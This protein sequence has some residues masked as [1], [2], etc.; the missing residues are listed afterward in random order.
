MRR[1]SQTTSSVF[2]L[3]CVPHVTLPLPL[4]IG[5]VAEMRRN[6]PVKHESWTGSA[7]LFR[8]ARHDQHLPRPAPT[9]T[10]DEKDSDND[11][12][13]DEAFTAPPSCW[14]R[15]KL[16]QESCWKYCRSIDVNRQLFSNTKS[17]QSSMHNHQDVEFS[18][19][20]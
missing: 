15:Q 2:W 17:W 9:T 19:R 18:R 13:N 14:I 11:N 20:V 7:T 8:G 3:K 1:A 12:D 6:N 5:I 10:S 16:R 4:D